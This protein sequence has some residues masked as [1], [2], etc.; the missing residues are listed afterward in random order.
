[1]AQLHCRRP[2]SRTRMPHAGFTL[3]ELL[4]TM[5]IA[6][7]LAAV[8]YP[9]Y[10]QHTVKARRAAVEGFMLELA[11]RQEQY[12]LDAR[13]YADSNTTLGVS[14]PTEVA[15]YYTVTVSADNTQTPPT[16]TVTATPK[17]SQLS[18]DG[19]CGTLTYTQAGVKGK[20]GT[21]SVADC[22]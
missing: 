16:H 6:G 21:G 3:I 1:M 18:Q 4:I 8:A 17:G 9:S 10:L 15:S 22:W 11:S 12:L 14:T 19:K 20:S 7:I 5:V 13:R 2:A